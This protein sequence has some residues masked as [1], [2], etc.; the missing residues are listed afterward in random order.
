MTG[1]AKRTT[2]CTGLTAGNEYCPSP[3]S[4][5]VYAVD[6]FQDG[7]LSCARHLAQ[8]VRFEAQGRDV[9]VRAYETRCVADG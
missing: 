9:T 4:F 3:S 5:R 2:G 6:S 8:V 7:A 1:R